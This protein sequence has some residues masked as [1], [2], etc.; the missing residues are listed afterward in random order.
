MVWWRRCDGHLDAG[1]YFV[2]RAFGK[3][4]LSTLSLAAGLVSPNKT[5]EGL[6]GGLA[7]SWTVGMLGAYLLQIPGWLWVGTVFGLTL[8]VSSVLGDLLASAFKRSA[9]LKDSGSLLPGH[10]GML[11]RLDS[12]L[13]SGAV[14]FHLLCALGL[15]VNQR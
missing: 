4:K 3:H 7:A 6:L 10:G 14:A 9:Q 15:V 8:S 1:G 12:H 13:I 11:D 2:G 5:V